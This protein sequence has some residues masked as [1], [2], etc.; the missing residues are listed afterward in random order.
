MWVA[1]GYKNYRPQ[2]YGPQRLEDLCDECS[3]QGLDG[4][5][6]CQPVYVEASVYG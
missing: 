3:V 4:I 1:F 2:H 6:M 5:I